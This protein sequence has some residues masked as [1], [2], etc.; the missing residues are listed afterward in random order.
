M[1]PSIAT[2]VHWQIACHRRYAL[3]ERLA[4]LAARLKGLQRSFECIQDCVRAYSP[5]L[6]HDELAAFVRC[7]P[8]PSIASQIISG[9]LV[10][11][12]GNAPGYLPL[13]RSRS[14]HG[15]A[16]AAEGCSLESNVLEQQLCKPQV[17]TRWHMLGELMR[18]QTGCLA[19]SVT[20]NEPLCSLRD[21][22]RACVARDAKGIGAGGTDAPHL[23]S[24]VSQVRTQAT[25]PPQP[26]TPVGR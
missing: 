18:T 6:W 25:R 14:A 19:Q 4:E 22:C 12:S 1:R 11:C 16:S 8:V 10:L 15:H 9:L 2:F 13:L 5:R 21:S 20:C 7:T 17:R 3:P 26:S 23:R 24:A